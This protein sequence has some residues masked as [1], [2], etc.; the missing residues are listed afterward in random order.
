MIV[1]EP[2]RS[3]F[4]NKKS[5]LIV[6]CRGENKKIGKHCK[7]LKFILCMIEILCCKKVCNWVSLLPNALFQTI[8]YPV[9]FNV[10]FLYVGSSSVEVGDCVLFW[11]AHT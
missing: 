4:I 3:P 1:Y 6:K 2:Q 5:F 11:V 9:Y 10:V 7:Q 8:H